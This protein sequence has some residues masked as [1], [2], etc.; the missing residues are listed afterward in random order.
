MPSLRLLTPKLTAA[1]LLVLITTLASP[2]LAQNVV[3]RGTVDGRDVALLSN[4]TWRFEERTALPE[5]CELVRLPVAFCGSDSRW[6]QLPFPPSPVINAMYQL[7]DRTYAMFIVEGL[8]TNDG[9]SYDNYRNAIITNFAGITGVA[10][11]NVP[12]LDEFTAQVD[13]EA[14]PSFVYSGEVEGLDFTY[15]NSTF[16]TD[17]AAVQ[18]VTYVIGPEY[19]DAHKLIHDEFLSLIDLQ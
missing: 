7:D 2:A 18:M 5:D 14:A 19:T 16:L 1:T 17:I 9:L 15:A 8:G 6:N 3:G 11:A 13:G 4:N 12:I 10:P